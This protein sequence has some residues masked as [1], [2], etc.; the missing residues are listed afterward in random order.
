MYTEK[1]GECALWCLGVKSL[2][3]PQPKKCRI[4]FLCVANSRES[5]FPQ[6]IEAFDFLLGETTPYQQYDLNGSSANVCLFDDRF[7]VSC[8]YMSSVKIIRR[9]HK[10]LLIG[11]NDTDMHKNHFKTT[12][13]I[14]H[15]KK[16]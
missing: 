7:G 9:E 13:L 3:S 15:Q 8:T 6:S 5:S 10:Q 2:V 4:C 11:A 16:M 14:G 1:Y 12:T